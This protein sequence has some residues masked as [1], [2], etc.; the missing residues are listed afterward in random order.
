MLQSMAA[1]TFNLP[2][3]FPSSNILSEVT[4]FGSNLPSCLHLCRRQRV[5]VVSSVWQTTQIHAFR[6]RQQRQPGVQ[7]EFGESPE[8]KDT[9]DDDNNDDDDDGDSRAFV[10]H[11]D[12]SGLQ[13]LHQKLGPLSIEANQLPGMGSIFEPEFLDRLHSGNHALERSENQSS[14][15]VQRE[16]PQTVLQSSRVL[17]PPE[18]SENNIGKNEKLVISGV[19]ENLDCTEEQ[20]KIVRTAWEKLVR[21]SRS[22]QLLNARKNS[23]ALL[24]TRKVVVLGG[25]SFGTAMAVIL[26]RNKPEME[27]MLL[28][29]DTFV[30]KSINEQHMN[31]KYF[32]QHQ[33]PRNVAATTD[34]KEAIWNAQFCIHAI[35]VQASSVFLRSIAEYVPAQLP[36]LSVSKGLEISTLEMMSQ[37]IP[38]ALGNPRQ[39]VAVISGPSFAIELMD[40]LPTALVAASRDKELARA[41][42]QLLASQYLR[43][44]MSTDVVGVEMA[45]ALKNVLAIAA[46]IVEGMKLGNN[47]M[48]A[49][50]AQGCSEIRWLAEKMGGKSTTLTGVSGSGDIML[51]CFVTLSRNRSVGVRLGSGEKLE[52]ILSSM[53][54]VAE[55]VATAGAVISLAKKYRVKMPVLTAVAKILANQLTPKTAVLALMSLPQVEEV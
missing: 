15:P 33:L 52:D 32:P 45:G 44:N 17:N 6:E 37:L 1:A 47:C 31:V 43:V 30:C 9:V 11:K 23:H 10:S 26:A 42:Q 19:A 3:L 2:I 12:Y 49:L 54:Q 51:T 34:A 24:S 25:G 40:K 35:P 21:W 48:A 50:V 46:G 28:I 29:R 4:Y 55:G 53:S 22:W 20:S 36:I 39:P 13:N 14:N 8:R 18:H 27:V 41:T 16:D 5:L 7:F 38:R